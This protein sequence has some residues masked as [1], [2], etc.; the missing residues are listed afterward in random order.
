MTEKSITIITITILLVVLVGYIA[1]LLTRLNFPIQY[2]M[3]VGS[4]IEPLNIVYPGI[5]Y[6]GKEMNINRCSEVENQILL[7]TYSWMFIPGPLVELC[8]DP[9]NP[10]R[11]SSAGMIEIE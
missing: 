11:V 10:N 1:P 9:N 4:A 7:Q 6:S 2:K 5:A 3:G 8:V